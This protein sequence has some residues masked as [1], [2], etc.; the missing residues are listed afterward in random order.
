MRRR[1]SHDAYWEGFETRM[2]ASRG[3]TRGVVE[4]KRDFEMEDRQNTQ[5]E[6]GERGRLSDALGFP[7]RW[8]PC[9]VS[10]KGEH[11]SL[12]LLRTIFVLWR[13]P[14][15]STTTHCPATGERVSE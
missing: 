4:G 7:S 14:T 8:Y 9:G 15:T 11:I 5:D 2:R 3:E 1:T 12:L 6:L 10:A 13:V